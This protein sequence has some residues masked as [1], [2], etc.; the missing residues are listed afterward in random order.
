[1]NYRSLMLFVSIIFVASPDAHAAQADPI[2][3]GAK[4]CTKQLPRYEREYAIPTH[5]LSAIASTE[6]GRYHTG[7][8]IKL[9]WPWTITSGGKGTFYD[10]K[11][12]AV[13]A[14]KK[15]KAKGV[16]NI[17]VGCM[18]V[19][20]QHHPDAFTSIENAFDPE[21]NV[22][23]AAHFLRTLYDSSG[24]WKKAAS[25]YHSKTPEHGTRYIGQVYDHW[26]QIIEKLREARLV[27]PTS[28]VVAMNELKKGAVKP[29]AKVIKVAQAEKP[30]YKAPR[31]K[32]IKVTTVETKPDGGDQIVTYTPASR[33]RIHDKG[34]IIVRYD[35]PGEEANKDS[36]KAYLTLASTAAQSS[37]SAGPATHAAAIAA[38]PAPEVKASVAI[39]RPE[40]QL[41]DI[42]TLKASV[43]APVPAQSLPEHA[44]SDKKADEVS[45]PRI[46]QVSG[47]RPVEDNITLI[48]RTGPNFIF[49]D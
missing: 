35:P 25:D 33:D 30:A 47:R 22:S 43:S 17:D 19:N 46:L 24:T 39:A 28:S 16:K 3:E 5:L 36:G 41:A 40:M 11:A 12:D 14:V 8:K 18:Q 7:L 20:L 21:Y 13:A 23:Y 38:A 26:Y 15:L 4:L 31:M 6:S 42:G 34:S 45:E 10:T 29:G 44:D 9:P 49:A 48:H 32:S 2:I 27:V 37:P 1:M